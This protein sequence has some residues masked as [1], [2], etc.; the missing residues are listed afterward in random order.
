MVAIGK[1]VKN[2]SRPATGDKEI[3]LK[4]LAGKKV[5]L[6]FYPKDST[7]GCTTEG[8]DFRDLHSGV[9]FILKNPRGGVLEKAEAA[10]S[11]T[12]LE[13][14]RVDNN[15]LKIIGMVPAEAHGAL[16]RRAAVVRALEGQRHD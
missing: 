14:V 5:V 2:F 12:D 3:S 8:Q 6:Y 7:P 15:Q 10:V 16:Q 9:V 13:I 11:P 4:D 1:K